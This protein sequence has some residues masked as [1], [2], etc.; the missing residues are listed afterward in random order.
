MA[1]GVDTVMVL[2]E[3]I[4]ASTCGATYGASASVVVVGLGS[5]AGE[6][7]G[8]MIVGGSGVDS[9]VGGG[10]VTTASGVTS[11]VVIGGGT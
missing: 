5:G 6:S 11:G 4:F 8:S 3:L 2:T 10:V 1:V 9:S 7:E